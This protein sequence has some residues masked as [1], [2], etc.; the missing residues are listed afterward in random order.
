MYS[1]ILVALEHTPSDLCILDHV[2]GLAGLCGSALVLIHV[3]D[4]WV[5]RNIRQL[6]LRESPEMRDDRAYLERIAAELAADGIA[7]DAVLATG[8]PAVEIAAAAERERCTLIAMST[9]GH[10]FFADLWRGSVA[11]QV[12]HR[13]LVPVLLVRA[14]NPAG[15][16]ACQ[17]SALESTGN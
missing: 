8:D 16:D 11:N 12:R 9:H 1:R 2:R 17:P 10:R 5:A 13:S 7:T 6:N 4:G 14:P 15:N 3:A